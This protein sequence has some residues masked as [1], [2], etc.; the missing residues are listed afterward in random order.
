MAMGC[1]APPRRA[2]GQASTKLSV[3]WFGFCVHAEQLPILMFSAWR[4]LSSNALMLCWSGSPWVEVPT[5]SPRT[6]T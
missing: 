3:S 4:V 5:T 1:A 2:C 6:S